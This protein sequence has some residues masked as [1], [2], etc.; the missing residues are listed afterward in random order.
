MIYQRL[1]TDKLGVVWSSKQSLWWP[2]RRHNKQFE[3]DFMVCNLTVIPQ[4]SRDVVTKA[5]ANSQFIKLLIFY[6]N[7][8]DRFLS[9]CVCCPHLSWMW[10]E[11]PSLLT[12]LFSRAFP[13]AFFFYVWSNSF[14]VLFALA[15]KPEAPTL[16]WKGKLWGVKPQRMHPLGAYIVA[17]RVQ[18]CRPYDYNT[19][20][21]SV[22]RVCA[23]TENGP[24]LPWRHL[25]TRCTQ[26]K[27]DAF[28]HCFVC[29]LE[30]NHL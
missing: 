22:C 27:I 7:A 16:R 10:V 25:Y 11:Y 6:K 5:I 8:G 19:T 3:F 12:D 24:N 13:R 26:S 18:H 17:P 15:L 20:T 28:F 23:P 14:L 30:I 2:S 21:T 29:I 4:T 9:M 1:F